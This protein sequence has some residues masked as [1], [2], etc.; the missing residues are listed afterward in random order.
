MSMDNPGCLRAILVHF[1]E[2]GL[3]GRNQPMFRR[4]LR[5][6]LRLKLRSLGKA[7]TVEDAVGVFLVHVPPDEPEA[8]VEEAA[9]GLQQVFGVVWLSVA[10]RL[11]PYAFSAEALER[12]RA[13]LQAHVVQMA[14]QQFK[15]GQTFCV[16]VNRANKYLPFTSTQKAADLG[17]AIR[18][19][20]PWTT[21][22]LRAPDLTF[23]VDLRC[24][25]SF[26]FG[27]KRRGP[28]GLPV[29]TSGRVL[30]LLSGGLDSPVAA[31]LMAKR[32][33]RV[34]FIHFTAAPVS[35]EEAVQSKIW[36][37]V[38]Q[39]RAY[40]LTA[41]VYLVPYVHFDLAL[42]RQKAVFDLVLF[43]RFMVRV[44]ERLAGQLHARALVSGDTLSQVASQTL[45]NLVS[46]SQASAM[47]VLRPLIGF[48]KEET[49]AL[50]EKI[51]TFAISVEPYKDCCALIS[52][53]PKTR[54]NAAKL[55]ELEARL[56][57]DY[58]QLIAHTLAEAIC[59][60][61]R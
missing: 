6:N 22:N 10:L 51:G 55:A 9:S 37:L 42:L 21:V 29:G 44:A 18:E 46:T 7:W 35:Q 61:N 40:T 57:P 20:T 14:R 17:Q 58:E 50:A 26:L 52:S 59:L 12:D 41:R 47:P 33:C 39:L 1:G 38:E 23:H 13:E 3:K 27:E 56:F 5:R 34:D 43:R 60:E 45:S 25:G 15:P 11:R 24:Q 36:R 32:G 54:S 2:L 30:A 31:Y 28:G 48:D 16:R 19:H 8:G 53:A 49:I 4:Q